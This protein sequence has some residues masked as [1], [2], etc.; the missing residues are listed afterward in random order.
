MCQRAGLLGLVHC[1]D[2]T[3]KSDSVDVDFLENSQYGFPL[4][5][6]IESS[7]ILI[8]RFLRNLVGGLD[9]VIC[10]TVPVPCRHIPEAER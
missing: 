1:R 5:L 8:D 4:S 9:G 2:V 6:F 7:Q 10:L 3:E